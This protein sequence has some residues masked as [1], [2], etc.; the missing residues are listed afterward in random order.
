VSDKSR[1]PTDEEV[2][3]ACMNYRH[4]FGLVSEE[5]RQ[6]LCFEAREWLRAWIKVVEAETEN[7]ENACS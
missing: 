5:A 4:D 1:E 2:R 3:Q 7:Q 6:K